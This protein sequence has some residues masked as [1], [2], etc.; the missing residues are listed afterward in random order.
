MKNKRVLAVL[1]VI[2]MTFVFSACETKAEKEE[3]KIVDNKNDA[4]HHLEKYL[5]GFYTVEDYNKYKEILENQELEGRAKSVTLIH[6]PILY[7]MTERG[8]NEVFG[9]RYLLL[10]TKFVSQNK[11]N[12]SISTIEYTN[13]NYKDENNINID[14][15]VTLKLM[16]ED[17]EKEAKIKGQA[18]LLK[19]N[20]V[21]LVN[22]D[23]KFEDD[24]QKMIRKQQQIE[25]E[26]R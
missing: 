1:L 16:Y 23:R 20:D 9:N 10:F 11:F 18:H 3:R 17:V 6:E 26:N 22:G 4:I 14:Y 12:T 5:N 24:I 21:W 25:Y 2:V 8:S 13:T 15:T 7:L 19:E